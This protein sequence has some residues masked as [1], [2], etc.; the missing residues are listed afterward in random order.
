MILHHTT[1]LPIKRLG[2]GLYDLAEGF[3]A[4][5]WIAQALY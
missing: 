2:V 4:R 3:S 1:N 5:L